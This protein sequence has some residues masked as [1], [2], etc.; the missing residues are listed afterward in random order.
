MVTD[1]PYYFH[2]DEVEAGRQIMTDFI[3]EVSA[4]VRRGAGARHLTVRVPA[5]LEFCAS[6]GLDPAGWMA[7]GLVDVLVAQP[8]HTPNANYGP[9]IGDAH[10]DPNYDCEPLPR[11]CIAA[12]T[13]LASICRLS[14]CIHSSTA[15]RQRVRRGGQGHAVQA[16]RGAAVGGP[17]RPHAGGREMAAMRLSI[18]VPSRCPSR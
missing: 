2:P 8:I 13:A 16:A 11:P 3:A 10:M 5:S 7:A 12:P 14:P 4:M 15:D 17:L 6:I 9:S 18:I 1:V